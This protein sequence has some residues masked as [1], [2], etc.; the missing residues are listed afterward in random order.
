MVVLGKGLI[1]SRHKVSILRQ[2]TVRIDNP[3]NISLFDVH[4]P[5]SE[6]AVELIG[7]K[8]YKKPFVVFECTSYCTYSQAVV[9]SPMSWVPTFLSHLNDRMTVVDRVKSVI[10]NIFLSLFMVVMDK[11]FEKLKAELKISPEKS[12][13]TIRQQAQIFLVNSDPIFEFPRPLTPNII[14][15]GGILASQPINVTNIDP[16]FD[17]ISS[18]KFGIIAF[19]SS[20]DF[21]SHPKL[22][23]NIYKILIEFS[24]IHWVWSLKCKLDKDYPNIHTFKWIPQTYLLAKESCV[25]FISHGGLNSIYESMYH[26]VPVLTIPLPADAIDNSVRLKRHGMS[27]IL[28]FHTK[29]IQESVLPSQISQTK[30]IRQSCILDKSCIKVWW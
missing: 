9:P 15:V 2:G 7:E 24:D 4:S 26:G 16:K 25:L 21:C 28:P 6:E 14:Q 5:L 27:E 30:T 3:G 19:G 10:S 17:E 20:L 1:T 13:T 18:K 11:N 12:L 22:L 8:K 29:D 23:A